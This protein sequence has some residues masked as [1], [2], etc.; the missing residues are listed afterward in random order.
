MYYYFPLN[1]T[2]TSTMQT[3]THWQIIMYFVCAWKSILWWMLDCYVCY[4]H[5]KYTNKS[6]NTL[7]WHD[8]WLPLHFTA[9]LTPILIYTLYFVDRR[10]CNLVFVIILSI[11]LFCTLL[12]LG[13][14]LWVH[15]CLVKRSV[16][17]VKNTRKT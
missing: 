17:T 11:Y 2:Y 14:L 4:L 5:S 8:V 13:V 6:H 1:S 15:E 3:D 16:L 12:K 10:K 7:T 9:H